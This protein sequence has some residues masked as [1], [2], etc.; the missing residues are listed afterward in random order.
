MN[1]PFGKEMLLLHRF[2]SGKEMPL[3][4]LFRIYHTIATVMDPVQF[5]IVRIIAIETWIVTGKETAL[6]MESLFRQQLI[7]LDPLQGQNTDI[8]TDPTQRL[9]RLSID[10]GRI[11]GTE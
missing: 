2:R 6:L 1:V 10:L 8:R 5:P 11:F 9:K 3:L 4:L 7:C